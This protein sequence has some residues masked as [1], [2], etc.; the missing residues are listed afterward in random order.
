LVSE[1]EEYIKL[2]DK[3]KKD[4]NPLNGAIGYLISCKWLKEY[5]KYCYYDSLRSRIK[6]EPKVTVNPGKISN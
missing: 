2:R 1:G 5:K 3:F 6:P 4:D